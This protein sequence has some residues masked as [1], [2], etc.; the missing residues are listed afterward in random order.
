MYSPTRRQVRRTWDLSGAPLT[1]SRHV[2]IKKNP[3]PHKATVVPTANNF[4]N[5]PFRR[6]NLNIAEIAQKGE[7]VIIIIIIMSQKK[8]Y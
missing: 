7:T 5:Y 4:Q 6:L 8:N 3:K 2:P 1:R